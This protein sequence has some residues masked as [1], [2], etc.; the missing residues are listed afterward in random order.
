MSYGLLLLRAAIGTTMF[1]HGTQKLFGWFGGHG[2][3]GTA[4][5]FGKLGFPAALAMAVFAGLA[6]AAGALFALGFLTPFAALAI[7]SVMVVAVGAVHRKNG[8]WNMGGGYEFNL[9]LW[10]VAVAVAATGPGR[11]SLDRLVG[12][13]DNLS[14]LWWGVGVLGA[15]LLGGA[16]LL[17]MRRAQPEPQEPEAADEALTRER[18]AERVTA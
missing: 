11:F 17:A 15:S 3:R 14:G 8:F 16:V 13:D 12:W 18:E 6:E 5:F 10:T 2:P 4:G 7:A 9:A 1:A